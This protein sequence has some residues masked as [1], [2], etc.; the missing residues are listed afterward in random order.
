[1]A[2]VTRGTGRSHASRIARSRSLFG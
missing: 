1:V 2:G